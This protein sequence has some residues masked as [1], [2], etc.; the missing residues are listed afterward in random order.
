MVDHLSIPLPD[1]LAEV[2]GDI[3]ITGHRINLYDVLWEYNQ[4]LSIEEMTLR[5]PTVKRSTILKLIAFYLDFQ[6]AVDTYLTSYQA[7]LD[8]KRRTGPA[9]PSVAELQRRLEQI[10]RTAQNVAQIS[11]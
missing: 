4:G 6:P 8:E 5:F 1:F 3:R 11:H 2:D 10:R 7:E 9:T